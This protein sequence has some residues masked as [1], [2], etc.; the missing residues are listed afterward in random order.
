VAIT[1]DIQGVDSVD[2]FVPL[3]LQRV[4]E[5][6]AWEFGAH[7]SISA[8]STFMQLSKVW[9]SPPLAGTDFIKDAK[10]RRFTPG[11]CMIGHTWRSGQIRWTTNIAGDMRLP[12]G[13]QAQAAGLRT[14]VW[15][16]ILCHNAIGVLEFLY[17][18]PSAPTHQELEQLKAASNL[19]YKFGVGIAPSAGKTIDLRV[20]KSTA[21]PED[22]L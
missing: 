7:W 20:A 16:P 18:R 15:V 9:I 19:G 1:D 12:R 22:N 10:I 17:S 2:A 6:F 4:C 13:I 3:L 14:G 21:R 11:E 5:T 8:D